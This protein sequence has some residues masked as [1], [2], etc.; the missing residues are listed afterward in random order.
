[1]AH[2]GGGLRIRTMITEYL[3]SLSRSLAESS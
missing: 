2:G 3:T 1:M